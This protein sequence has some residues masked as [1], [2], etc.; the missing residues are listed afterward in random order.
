M[1][2]SSV[3]RF[4]LLLI[5]TILWSTAMHWQ[6]AGVARGEVKPPKFRCYVSGIPVV[7]VELASTGDCFENAVTQGVPANLSAN[8]QIIRTNTRMDFLFIVLYWAVFVCFARMLNSSW[9]LWIIAVISGSALYDA[10]EN[11]RILSGLNSLDATRT[12]EGWLPRPFSLA[13]WV[14]LALALL[15]LGALVWW[16]GVPIPEVEA[17]ARKKSTAVQV[18]SVY[19][20]L[21]AAFITSGLLTFAG[22]VIPEAMTWAGFTFILVFVLL[23]ATQISLPTLN[24]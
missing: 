14:L 18:Q 16:K 19:R 1:P 7:D 23:F 10:F 6:A 15:V 2:Q 20:F 21:S 17:R 4:L 13:K 12:V 22:L 8:G 24:G 9:S 3:R 5:A 11:W